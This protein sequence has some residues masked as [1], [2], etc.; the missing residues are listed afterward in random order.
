MSNG[1]DLI[2]IGAG[3][4]GCAAAIH[5]ASQGLRV[6]IVER[7]QFPRDRPGETLH[8]GVEPILQQLGVLKEIEQLDCVR[9]HGIGVQW[10]AASEFQ[11]FGEDEAGPWRGWQIYRRDLDAVLLQKAK[12]LNVEIVMPA[13]ALAVIVEDKRVI[14]VETSLGKFYAKYCIDAS[15]AWHWLT[16]KLNFGRQQAAMKLYALY[17][18]GK[19][20]YKAAYDDPQIVADDKGWTWI[21]RVAADH[22]QW[23]RVE[24]TKNFLDKKWQPKVLN[25]LQPLGDARSADVSWRI[26]NQLAGSGFFLVGDAAFV[27]DPASSH[28]VLKALLSGIKA[29]DLTTKIMIK[30]ILSTEAVLNYQQWLC[31]WY[32]HDVGELQVL[33]QKAWKT[34]GGQSNLIS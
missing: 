11:A 8:P 32:Q 34:K 30:D 16:R 28:G 12:D 13:K 5:A 24:F 2:V 15:G 9:H 20:F 6:C 10:N 17:G 1:F 33:Y 29:A 21:A 3:P 22:Y 19:G 18:Y 4:A 23:T 26:A 27:L 7:E 31:D 14:G 25:H